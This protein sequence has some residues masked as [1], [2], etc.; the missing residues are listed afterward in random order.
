MASR[1]RAYPHFTSLRGVIKDGSF[2]PGLIILF[3]HKRR[4]MS[5]IPCFSA[6]INDVIISI[7]STECVWRLRLFRDD[8]ISSDR[9]CG[10][11]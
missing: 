1:K 6:G 9:I 4:I 5:I 3:P 8:L 11:S 7:L 10:S 2:G